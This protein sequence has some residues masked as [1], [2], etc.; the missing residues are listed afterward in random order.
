MKTIKRCEARSKHKHKTLVIGWLALAYVTKK[1]HLIIIHKSKVMKEK[2]IV[3]CYGAGVFYG[4]IAS[5]NGQEAELINVRQ[6]WR[7]SGAASLMQLASE[8]VSR[9]RD[10][11]FT[12]SVD[13][14]IVTQVIEIIPCTEKAIKSIESV[15]VWRA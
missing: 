6:I 7:W 11:K 13:R 9:P 2:F 10:C 12:V 1:Q 15:E 3:R 4:E 5:R 8:G 14:L